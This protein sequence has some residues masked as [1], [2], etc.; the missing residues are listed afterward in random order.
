MIILEEKTQK[1]EFE[2]IETDSDWCRWINGDFHRIW[3][4]LIWDV[5]E[6]SLKNWSHS[7]TCPQSMSI[8]L[9]D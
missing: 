1:L 9:W 8:S 5:W 7:S 2:R 6:M 3:R 4:E